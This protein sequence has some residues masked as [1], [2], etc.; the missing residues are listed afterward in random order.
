MPRDRQ[1]GKYEWRIPFGKENETLRKRI[2]ARL[3]WISVMRRTQ[4][5]H[6]AKRARPNCNMCNA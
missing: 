3:L 5:T 4:K 6:R 1:P 2:S